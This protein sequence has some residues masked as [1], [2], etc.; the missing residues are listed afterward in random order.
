M[1]SIHYNDREETIL[2]CLSEGF[3]QTASV[4]L[5]HLLFIYILCYLNI[6]NGSIKK[7]IIQAETQATREKNSEFSQQE[8]S[9]WPF[10]HWSDALPLGSKVTNFPHT[11]SIRCITS[12][13]TFRIPHDRELQK[14]YL[15]A[16]KQD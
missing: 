5:L 2:Q 7:D 9:L 13:L 4:G 10:A 14:K 1:N 3:K 16:I 6:N 15:E 11:T 8:L 12:Q